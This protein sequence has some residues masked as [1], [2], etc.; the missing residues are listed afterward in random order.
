MKRYTAEYK[1]ND[2]TNTFSFLAS[3][4][5]DAINKLSVISKDLKLVGFS[6][7]VFQP[8]IHRL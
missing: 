4:K 7:L 5:Q 2:I 8:F 3:N 6:D 1:Y